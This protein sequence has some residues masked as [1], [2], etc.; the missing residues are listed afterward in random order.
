MQI[1]GC[2][3]CGS[4]KGR[5]CSRPFPS[6]AVTPRFEYRLRRRD[7]HPRVVR[8]RPGEERIA[9][10]HRVLADHRLAAQNGGTGVDSH[11]VAHCGVPLSRQAGM[12]RPGGQCAQ[13]HTLIQLHMAA[14]H[15]R[16]ADNDACAVVDEE[17]RPDL[18][19]GVDVDTRPAVGVLRHHPGD[20][21]NCRR[22]SSWAMRYTKMA[23]SPG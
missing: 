23:N 20:H 22:Y 11:I 8:H 3:R 18:R 21:G 17:P 15:R 12:A 7:D 16:L 1:A 14:D 13:R 9:A 10:H 4:I 2:L 19:A 5:P 6:C